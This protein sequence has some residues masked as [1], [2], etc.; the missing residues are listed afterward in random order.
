[1]RL[2]HGLEGSGLLPALLTP[3]SAALLHAGFLHLA[4]NLFMLAICGVAV[5][6]AIGWKN[7]LALYLV[8]AGTAAAA[9]WASNPES[10][11]PMIGAS[12]AISAVVGAYA[13]L[14]GKNRV[15]I[16]NPFLARAIHVA[17][18]AAAWIG[19]QLLFGYASRS[20]EGPTI[21]ILAHVGGFLAGL[22]LATPLHRL[23]WRR[24]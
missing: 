16:S 9:Q 5:E 2:T 13:L 4:L 21:A 18:L 12:G 8:G 23:H 14:F 6:R 20:S 17:W 24:A 15:T 19:L 3:F 1:M 22:A 7:L 11:I 10:Q